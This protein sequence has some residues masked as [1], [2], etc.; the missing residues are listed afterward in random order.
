[1]LQRLRAAPVCA[2]APPRTAACSRWRS[3]LGRRRSCRSSICLLGEWARTLRLRTTMAPMAS[4][5]RS[6]GREHRAIVR[7]RCALDICVI[8]ASQ[9][10]RWTCDGVRVRGSRV[11]ATHPRRASAG[12]AQEWSRC[13]GWHRARD[14]RQAISRLE[15]ERRSDSGLAKRAQLLRRSCRRQAEFGG[16]TTDDIQHV[17]GRSLVLEGFCSS[18]LLACSASNSRVFS[19]AMTAWSAKV[20][21]SAICVVGERPGSARDS[22]APIGFHRAA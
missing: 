16:R 8:S 5:W 7:N 13:P 18:R 1:M 15:P 17:A 20:L 11:P 12:S 19:M 6:S 4:P 9:R 10:C 14:R 22:D 3:R 21:R 2:P